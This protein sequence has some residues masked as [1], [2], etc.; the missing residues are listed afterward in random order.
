MLYETGHFIFLVSIIKL[1]ISYGTWKLYEGVN[2]PPS[3]FLLPVCLD[4]S[5]GWDARVTGAP[6]QKCSLIHGKGL[7]QTP[8]NPL[9]NVPVCRWKD[10]IWVLLFKL[11]PCAEFSVR[12]QTSKRWLQKSRVHYFFQ[13][14]D[15]ANTT[16][17]AIW[18]L[19]VHLILGLRKWA[20]IKAA[21]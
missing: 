11:L 12:K 15:R 10:M 9:G 21:E 5:W 20:V 19:P 14:M 8:G 1:W 17:E 7:L 6:W 18:L 16:T 4:T 3:S 13:P 2:I